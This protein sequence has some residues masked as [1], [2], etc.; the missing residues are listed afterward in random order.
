MKK[1]FIIIVCITALLLSGCGASETESGGE[2][3]EIITTVF[4]AYDFARHIA[5]DRA[6]VTLLIPPG[7]ESHS[8]EP[9][10]QDM[11]RIQNGLLICNGGE[12]EAWVGEMIEGE[13][14]AIS[15]LYM[16]DCVEPL[17]EEVREGM[18]AR[19]PEEEAH[20]EEFDEHVWTSPVN[21]ARIC[22][23][24]CERLSGLDPE[25]AGYYRQNCAEYCEALY[26]L[27]AAFREAAENAAYKTLIFADRFPVRYFVEEYGFDYYAAFPGCADDAEP[28]AKTVAFLID[29]VREEHI[30]AVFYI[31]FSNEKMADV[32]CEDTG[33]KKLLFHS[34]HNVTAQELEEGV[35]YLELMEGNL[36]NLKEALG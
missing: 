18:Q 5:G 13:D 27:D 22:T 25:N 30:P 31:E 28:S 15:P 36:L 2:G 10:A 26:A 14:L 9:T 33:C 24:I 4:P 12:S 35:G 34:C 21:A 17:E 1:S 29:K 20:E 23:A 19:E 32:I 8:F 6:R 7:S 3:L 11:I 16:M